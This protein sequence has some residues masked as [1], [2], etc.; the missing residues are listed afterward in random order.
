MQ[1]IEINSQNN[2][3]PKVGFDNGFKRQGALNIY[4]IDRCEYF[5]L[6]KI[7]KFRTNS[8]DKTHLFYK[9]IET[10]RL[11]ETTRTGIVRFF[12]YKTKMVRDINNNS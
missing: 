3:E 8:K 1:D 6:E 7:Q 12:G 5:I 10:S 4:N 11:K 9:R 2:D